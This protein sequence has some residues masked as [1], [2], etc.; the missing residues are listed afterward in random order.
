ML[1]T[2]PNRVERTKVLAER[3]VGRTGQQ[4][5]AEYQARLAPLH[6]TLLADE[7]QRGRLDEALVLFD[8]LMAAAVADTA[9]Q[10]GTRAE[11]L[12][13]RCEARRLRAKPGDAELAL[14]DLE[15]ALAT[16]KEPAPAHRA[17]GELHR[18]AGR[19]DA[20]R[21][22]F[23]RYL[24]LAPEAPDAGLVRQTLKAGSPS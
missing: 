1:A 21:S 23:E 22:S 3:A 14:T 10:Q 2:H 6:A 7:L 5:R 13:F 4:R 17:L 19:P 18:S 15:A 11:R 16:G 12:F 9:T 8:R 20:A 24:E